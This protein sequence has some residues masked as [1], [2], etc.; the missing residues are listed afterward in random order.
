MDYQ[1]HAEAMEQQ[2]YG[3]KVLRDAQPENSAHWQHFQDEITNLTN[4]MLGWERVQPALERLD[5]KIG[6]ARVNAAAAQRLSDHNE[7]LTA[8]KFAG[9]IGLVLLIVCVLA[10]SVAWWV[11]ALCVVAL[12]AA[13]GL[14]LLGTRIRR[15]R[16]GLVD[17]A[18]ASLS[19]LLREWRSTAPDGRS[20]TKNAPVLVGEQT[21]AF[22]S[23]VDVED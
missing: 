11:V 3:K 1:K 18:E 13:G 2:I 21:G 23:E 17:A 12:L 9:G 16:E 15:E 19:E 8:S 7:A 6:A 22:G 20:W 4:Q 14:T 10:D 5:R